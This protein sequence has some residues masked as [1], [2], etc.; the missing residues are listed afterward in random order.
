MIHATCMALMIL[1]MPQDETDRPLKTMRVHRVVLNDTPRIALVRLKPNMWA[2]YDTTEAR[3]A[4]AWLGS[5]NWNGWSFNG[6]R[7][8]NPTIKADRL[9]YEARSEQ[10]W[11]VQQGEKR[12]IPQIRFKG[13]TFGADVVHFH[14]V[15][16]LEDQKQVELTESISQHETE[17]GEIVLQRRFQFVGMPE[18][19]RIIMPL[20][21][22]TLWDRFEVLGTGDGKVDQETWT[23]TQKRDGYNICGI[24]W[25]K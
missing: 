17:E 21:G 4:W 8:P 2:A 22:N 16:L 19:T 15:L 14:S 18:K 5:V 20:L 24:V 3:L 9:L 11:S 7:G 12:Y 10:V 6:A 25:S 13:Y 23:L 1:A